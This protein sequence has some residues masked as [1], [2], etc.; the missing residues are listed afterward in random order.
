MTLFDAVCR[1]TRS[2][3]F[4]RLPLSSSLLCRAIP[5]LLTILLAAI[6]A[7]CFSTTTQRPTPQ[8]LAHSGPAVDVSLGYWQSC[9]VRT[10]G[11]IVCWGQNGEGDDRQEP[12]GADFQS[13]SVGQNHACAVRNN[14]DLTCWDANNSRI[15]LHEGPFVSVETGALHSCAL[16]EN[17]TVE[18]WPTD[19][20][21]QYPD[22]VVGQAAPPPES[23]P[24]QSV[25]AGYYH[26]CAVKDN[27][28]ALC[29]GN[30]ES[31]QSRPPEGQFLSIGAGAR[32]TCGVRTD[33][34]VVCWGRYGSGRLFEGNPGSTTDTHSPRKGK[35]DGDDNEDDSQS[36]QH[37]GAFQS[38][39]AGYDYTCGIRPDGSLAC[40]GSLDPPW[41]GAPTLTRHQLTP[42]EGAF[43]SVSVH[44][45][46]SCAVRTDSVI[47]CWGDRSYGHTNPPGYVAM[48]SN[49]AEYLCEELPDGSGVCRAKNGAPD[50]SVPTEIPAPTDYTAI[51]AGTLNTCGLTGYAAIVCWGNTLT[52][53]AGEFKSIAHGCAVTLDGSIVCWRPDH[54]EEGVTPPSGEFV[55]IS[56]GQTY[57]GRHHFCA[58]AA[59]GSAHCWGYD[60]DNSIPSPSGTFRQIS[61][62][63]SNACG[64]RP[65]GAL[66]CWWFSFADL[67]HEPVPEGRFRFVSVG[68]D[69]GCAI[70]ENG[71]VVCWGWDEDG[72][73]SPPRGSFTSVSVGASHSC[74]IRSDGTLA[75]WGANTARASGE[76]LFGE[77]DDYE[78]HFGQADPPQGTFRAV[79]AG[80]W[81]TCGIRTDGRATCWGANHS[82][83]QYTRSGHF[84]DRDDYY[85]YGQAAPPGGNR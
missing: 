46:R 23:G 25:S 76:T 24:F 38:V 68:R 28:A 74:G 51:V 39:S 16:R 37:T 40:W 75:C 61:V 65:D 44:G 56:G 34:S 52:P 18:C 35:K 69:H 71:R 20:A 55:S 49:G 48:S 19:K 1:H 10:D 41:R 14:G 60:F 81:H 54:L 21:D 22:R 47:I 66:H 8:P 58:I 31:G 83:D 11:R 72:K 15:D 13:V 78:T 5:I 45:R 67:S 30:N 62:H 27:G 17:G 26:N 36:Y 43:R 63:G 85:Y 6:L 32:H 77:G 2:G 79:A 12:A 59:D 64:I 3:S 84:Y 50:P 57:H 7:A 4:R 73:A 70:R 29:W 9:S 42:P 82:A 53:P 80:K 33:G